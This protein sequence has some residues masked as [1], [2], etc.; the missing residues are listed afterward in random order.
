MNKCCFI[1]PY[2]G[3][4][5]K[6]FPVF[7]K[8]C[9][10]NPD[11]NWLIYT[12]DT[13]PYNY[14]K[15]VKVIYI[16]FQNLRKRIESNFQ[17]K[18]CLDRPYKLCDLRPMYGLIFE[19]EIKQYSF[20]GHCDFDI[21]IGNLN[22]FITEDMLVKYDKIFCLG[23]MTLYKNDYSNNRL[24]M[25]QFKGKELYK[26]V[27][28]T[29]ES[30]NFDE[31]WKDENNINQIYLSQGKQVYTQDLS[32]NPIIRKT[33]FVR[34][35][36]KG[37]DKFPK[38]HGYETEIYKNA[39]YIWEKGNV[40]RL[41]KKNGELLRE[42]FCYMHFQHRKMTFDNKILKNDIFKIVPNS[43]L[44]IEFSTI[45]FS[46]F[47]KIKRHTINNHYY[48]AVILPRIKRIPTKLKKILL[49]K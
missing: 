10:W 45:N 22:K 48:Q 36:Y 5:P 29:N 33:A 6:F 47:S 3:K 28:S 31:E 32:M 40:Y 14:P 27:L 23:H 44:P 42:D 18:I 39:L 43:F 26:E 17:F 2:F 46:N 41:Y 38:S 13:T 24:F 35:I 34:T 1:A 37:I 19:K 49:N 11:Y 25:S 20:W 9:S 16:S 7:L 12:D 8:T 15:N 30:C 21:I 4:L